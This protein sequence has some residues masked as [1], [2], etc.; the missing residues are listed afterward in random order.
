MP[1]IPAI[2]LLYYYK[3]FVLHDR[4]HGEYR[5]RLATT[6]EYVLPLFV[7]T[8][9]PLLSVYVFSFSNCNGITTVILTGYTKTAYIAIAVVV[10]SIVTAILVTGILLAMVCLYVKHKKTGR[11][12]ETAETSNP[13]TGDEVKTPP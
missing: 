3:K 4:L 9:Y 7:F 5:T 8:H 11:K 2:Y 13:V 10:T 12:S 1:T 6:L